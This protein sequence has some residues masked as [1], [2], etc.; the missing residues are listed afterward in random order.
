VSGGKESREVFQQQVLDS[1]GGPGIVDQIYV[2]NISAGYST[3]VGTAAR[4]WVRWWPGSG[5]RVPHLP[6]CSKH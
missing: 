1:L 4:R 6:K 3:T 5:W 2:P